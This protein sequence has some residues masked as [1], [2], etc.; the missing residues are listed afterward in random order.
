MK[1]RIIFHIDVNNA[2][3]SWT[4]ANMLR[5]GSGV[6]IRE[7]PS[8][9]GGDESAR[10]GIV[11]A[12]SPVAKRY[13]IKT[14]ETLYS[15]RKKCPNL[16]VFKGDMN[17]YKKESNKLY[18]YYLKFTPQVER[19]SI[20]ECYLDMTGTNYLYDNL[21][22]L[23]YSMQKE[24]YDNFGITVNI[25]IAN[26]KLCAKMA[27]DFE[28]PNKVHT[29]FKEE[30]KDK[31]WILPIEEL[32]MI[33]KATSSKLRELGINTIED[34]AKT[35]LQMLSKYFKNSAAFMHNSANGIDESLVISEEHV[36]KCISTTETLP[37]DISDSKE[38]KQILLKQVEDVGRSLR[39]QN[40][41][42]TTVAVIFRTSEFID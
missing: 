22:E 21:I 32:Y 29:L 24:I 5:N 23:A 42:T 12:K 4:A 17:L 40:A 41:Y 8:V 9:I 16:K 25:G 38:L 18:E 33:G 26:N 20:D 13:G 27:S 37:R 11:T 7:I 19:F 36:N 3:L 35:D 34:L 30:I 2:F 39:K 1:E 15:A 28:K 14:A 10:R 6:D 31:M